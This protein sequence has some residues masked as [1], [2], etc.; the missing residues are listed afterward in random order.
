[1]IELRIV[2][3]LIGLIALYMNNL[4][5][6]RNIINLFEFIIWSL[7]WSVFVFLCIM[8]NLFNLIL[9]TFNIEHTFHLIIIFSFIVLYILSYKTYIDSKIIQRKIELIV[10]KIA[11]NDIKND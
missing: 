10:R 9:D 7:I 3:I 8:P 1:M 11:S 4:N 6:K 2:G 5:Y